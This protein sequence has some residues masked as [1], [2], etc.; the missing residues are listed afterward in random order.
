M[1]RYFFILLFFSLSLFSKVITIQNN[2]NIGDILQY[3]KIYIDHSKSLTI[4]TIKDKN[5]TQSSSQTLSYGYSPDFH[6]WVKFTLH[7]N[8][9]KNIQK[10][11]EYDNAL[12]SHIELY[13][14]NMVY[15][16]G[17]FYM[18]DD[19]TSLKPTF[20]ISLKSG[21]TKTFY[22]KS[23]SHITTL[24]VKLK[25]YNEK[26]FYT[27]E[28]KYQAILALFFGAMMV[29]AVY[30]LFI[31]LFT[32]DI[33]YL[34]YVGY[35]FGIML[36]HTIYVGVFNVYL[37]NLNLQ[38]YEYAVFIVAFPAIFLGLFTKYFLRTNLYPNWDRILNFFIIVVFISSF[39]FLFTSSLNAYR[40][41]LPFLLLLYLIIL[42]TY[43]FLKKNKQSKY[44][45]IGWVIFVSAGGA[46]YLSSS[47]VIVLNEAQDYMVELLIVLEAIIFSIAL[48]KKI[49]ILQEELLIQ[50]KTENIRL[51]ELVA[52]KVEHIELL[53][54]ELN[55]R[56]KNN[57]QTVIT[58]LRLQM[59]DVKDEQAI[60]ILE[61]T[62]NRL[63][64]MSSLHEYLHVNEGNT[65]IDAKQYFSKL[66]EQLTNTYDDSQIAI[67]YQLETTLEN[68]QGIYCGL[69]LNELVTN[70]FKYAFDED[71]AGKVF[72]SLT[73]T[74]NTYQLIV[75]DNG[76]GFIYDENSDSL[77]LKMVK[78]LAEHQLHGSFEINSSN[79]V[80]VSIKW[81][82]DD[83]S[84]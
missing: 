70:S 48:A 20:N 17:L 22:L 29:L 38:I 7:N 68:D 9:N 21:E 14:N 25:L 84:D 65:F 30:N 62:K 47:G 46:M 33:S 66:M 15:K 34:F 35:M 77:G 54:K 49:N 18:K 71:E 10:V 59:N 63:Y 79:G 44:I 72:I 42:T 37:W 39:I 19:R 75:Q 69:I 45:L 64:A 60:K 4:D 43:A 2:D 78:L 13:D 61:V 6:V 27:K 36:H 55:H 82:G 26:Y 74:D 3:S 41:L 8:T 16:E 57:M 76:K 67:E 40:N 1:L 83:K 32:R 11:L 12:T 23:Y 53:M 50:R 5:F 81:R 31:F 52:K 28:V 51:E 56:V 73:K 58:L 80:R 24:I